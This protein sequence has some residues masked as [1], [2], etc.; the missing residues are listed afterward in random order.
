[1]STSGVFFETE[2]AHTC[3]ETSRFSVI[4]GESTVQCEGRVVRVER[5]K[6]KFGIAV[7]LTSYIF[8]RELRNHHLSKLRRERAAV[9]RRGNDIS[10]DIDRGFRKM[11][12]S[13]Y[14]DSLKQLVKQ[15]SQLVLDRMAIGPGLDMRAV[16]W[17]KAVVIL[18]GDAGMAEACRKTEAVGKRQ[19][20]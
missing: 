8:C 19:R 11:Y 18:P 6:S 3:G 10:K 13:L 9:G 14:R 4:F 2:Q 12:R 15:R 5:F 16:L 17:T 7:E 1:M 20:T